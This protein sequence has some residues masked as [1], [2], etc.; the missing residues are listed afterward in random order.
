MD[1]LDI[2]IPVTVTIPVTVSSPIA[3]PM[4]IAVVDERKDWAEQEER[5][6]LVRRPVV[7]TRRQ[8]LV[9]FFLCLGVFLSLPLEDLPPLPPLP[10]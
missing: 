7:P 3:V 10:D 9:S 4:V 6:V 1:H 2:V 8:N 5:E